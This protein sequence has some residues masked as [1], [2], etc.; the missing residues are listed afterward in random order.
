VGEGKLSRDSRSCFAV[1]DLRLL[2][3]HACRLKD[4]L[5]IL[6]HIATDGGAE[7]GTAT[8][9][10]VLCGS[11]GLES[12]THIILAVQSLQPRLIDARQVDKSERMGL[13]A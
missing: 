6:R 3:G 11:E 12:E 9:Y 7:Q 13:C 1:P 10:E 4:R 2:R 5:W 8:R